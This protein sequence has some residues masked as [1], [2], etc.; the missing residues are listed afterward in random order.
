M[1]KSGS[2]RGD[3]A[4]DLT[5]LTESPGFRFDFA[6]YSSI[7]SHPAHHDRLCPCRTAPRFR[8]AATA[9]M[10]ARMTMA[11]RLKARAPWALPTLLIPL[12]L[13]ILW[14]ELGPIARAAPPAPDRAVTI[15]A[16]ALDGVGSQI[17]P[18]R[19]TGALA[20]RSEDAGFGGLS[21][22][23][24]AG[25][26]RLVAVTDAGQW[27]TLTPQDVA[28]RLAGV[29]AARMAGVAS[30]AEKSDLDAEAIVL[31]PDGR[32]LISMEQR[33]R[34]LV[35]KGQA[36]PFQP[37]G[38][39]FHTAAASWPPNG[40]GESLALLPGGQTL[41]ISED[42]RLAPGVAMALLTAADGTTRQIGIPVPEHFA[43][44]DVTVLDGQ[45]LLLLH[46][47]FDGVSVEA[48]ITL[49]DLAP[50]LAGGDCATMRP[51]VRWGR[52]APWPIDNMEGLTLVRAG[53]RT[54]LFLV[55]DDN[56]NPAQRTL[57][58]RLELVNPLDGAQS[59]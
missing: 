32:T 41:W 31:T 43:P 18:F 30:G 51:L 35:L 27:L 59:P 47:K 9:A 56:F 58:L 44:T 34:I 45:R 20:L 16:T 28:G 23:A 26:G 14:S 46:R 8:V 49:V 57:L 55:S 36:P 48:A 22:L 42:A 19:L 54:M 4:A 29:G 33:H 39:I 5:L 40:G 25:E 7:V 3:S 24:A 38:L 15:S 21:G 2:V 12:A 13:W 53:G 1:R 11:N 52:D 10:V 37:E 6:S 17:G 50:V